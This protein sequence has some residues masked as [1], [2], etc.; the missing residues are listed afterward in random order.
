MPIAVGTISMVTGVLAPGHIATSLCLAGCPVVAQAVG[1]PELVA[2]VLGELDDRMRG[3]PA[4]LLVE[5]GGD[6][7]AEPLA[8]LRGTA[9]A[10]VALDEQDGLDL[11]V[12][13]EPQHSV[14]SQL[15][16]ADGRAPGAR[17]HHLGVKTGKPAGDPRAVAGMDRDGEIEVQ[18]RHPRNATPRR[19]AL[20]RLEDVPARHPP[21]G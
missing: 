18:V 14:L 10:D 1:A 21:I 11:A 16:E 3:R 4:Q 2:R 19:A 20:A 6:G 8:L 17:L 7:R 12:A 15:A 13:A 9:A 5:H